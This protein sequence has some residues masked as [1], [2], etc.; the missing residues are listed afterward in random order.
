MM[1]MMLSTQYCTFDRNLTI[2]KIE[3]IIPKV[4]HHH[5]HYTEDN[6]K[7]DDTS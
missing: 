7:K 2:K 4:D 1:M 6:V 5:H 3:G